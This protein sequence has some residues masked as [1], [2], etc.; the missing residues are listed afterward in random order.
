VGGRAKTCRP[1][2][3]LIKFTDRH[4][5]DQMGVMVLMPVTIPNMA[6]TFFYYFTRKLRKLIKRRQQKAPQAA[7]G[8]KSKAPHCCEALKACREKRGNVELS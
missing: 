1:Y 5:C 2:T 3:W 6:C 4:H 8:N 7:M